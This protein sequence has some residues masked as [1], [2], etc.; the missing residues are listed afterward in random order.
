MSVNFKEENKPQS[1]LF[2]LLFF[3]I[4]YQVFV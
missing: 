1:G 3:F 2:Q 4:F